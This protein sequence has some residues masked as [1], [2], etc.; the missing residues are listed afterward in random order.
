MNKQKRIDLIDSLRGFSLLGILLANLLIFQYGIWGKDYIEFFDISSVD[1]WVYSFIKV[2]IENSFLPI[3][4]FLFGY[5]I[6]LIRDQLYENKQRVKWHLFRRF[7]A[8]ASLGI[9][10]SIFL[11]EGDILLLY[12]IIGVFLLLFVNRKKRTLLIWIIIFFSLLIIGDIASLFDKDQTEDI[13]DM[14][15]LVPYIQQA[16]DIYSEGSYT[17]IKEFRNYAEDPLDMELKDEEALI[18]LILLPI[19]M[20]PLFLLGMYAAN[21]K[22]FYDPKR[23]LYMKKAM[24]FLGI[25]A[26]VKLMENVLNVG[27]ISGDIF[28]ALGYIF[29]FSYLYTSEK[30]KRLLQHLQCIGKLSLTNYL[31]QSII[32]TTIFYGYGL[33]LFGKI[34]V[35]PATLLGVIIF[36]FQIMMSKFYLKHF[37]YGPFEK[38]VRICTYLSL[39]KK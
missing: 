15:T 26:T 24:L 27:L 33:G 38:V 6:I 20:A 30:V 29:L 12:G 39:S 5:S 36:L 22:W 2:A 23:K 3:F 16:R 25:G 18:V 19:I 34:G 17:D 4:S 11:W 14:D 1:K 9:L 28:L 32:C 31:M 37:R 35:L 13:V 10:H 7:I 21:D 8:L